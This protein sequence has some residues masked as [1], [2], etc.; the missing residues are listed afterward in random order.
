M[1][2]RHIERIWA[3]RQEWQA[4]ARDQETQV[5]ANVTRTST[6]CIIHNDF[7]VYLVSVRL[8]AHFS[9]SSSNKQQTGEGIVIRSDTATFLANTSAH[10]QGRQWNMLDTNNR[11]KRK[12]TWC[13]GAMASLTLGG[14]R[15]QLFK[16][17]GMKLCSKHSSKVV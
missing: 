12:E 15:V 9:E 14:P 10:Q 16:R 2:Q 6:L 8:L 5:L 7:I 1:A 3:A 4:S 11:C 13:G 17:R